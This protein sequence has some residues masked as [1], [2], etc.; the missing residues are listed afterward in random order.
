M[1]SIKNIQME[2]K[3]G[4]EENPWEREREK[5]EEILLKKEKKEGNGEK[6][7]WIDQKIDMERE[8]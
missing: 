6:V 8:R 1:I 4:R 7:T 3:R 2:S 5:E